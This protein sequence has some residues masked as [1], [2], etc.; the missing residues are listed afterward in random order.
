MNLRYITC[1][2]PRENIS[3]DDAI[4]ILTYAPNVEFGIQADGYSMSNG[5]PRNIWLRKILEKSNSMQKPLNIALHVNYDW[6]DASCAYNMP[7]D[8]LQLRD[9]VHTQ[10]GTPL[11][12]R[13][14]FNIGDGTRMNIDVEKVQLMAQQ[15]NGRE[16]IF[17]YN[18][19]T[20]NA[21]YAFHD[22]NVNFS[23][24]HDASYGAG[25]SPEKWPEPLYST[26]HKNG[27]AGGLCEKNVQQCLDSVNKFSNKLYNGETW[28]DA[29]GQLMKQGSKHREMDLNKAMN[30][31]QAAL[32]WQ[33]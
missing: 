31:I 21:I 25:I 13:W 8:L 15:L 1:S 26:K 17:P 16:I 11:I 19:I 20:K 29:E 33:K 22:M 5:T 28:I 6:C 24:L 23:I 32:Q 4:K 30:Y 3:V 14:Q 2:D 7:S 27:Y 10:T 9:M 18:P 12:Q